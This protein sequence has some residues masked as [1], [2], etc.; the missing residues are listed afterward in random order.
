MVDETGVRYV[1]YSGD[2]SEGVTQVT[3]IM[4][5]SDPDS[6]AITGTLQVIAT[7]EP[8]NATDPS[9]TWSVENGTGS[10]S[11]DQS[12]MLTGA[13]AGLVTVKAMANDGSGIEGTIE[14]KVYLQ[15]AINNLNALNLSIYPN[16]SNGLFQIEVPGSKTN[17]L[18]YE[19]I[20]VMGRTIRKGVFSRENS[21]LNLLESPKGMYIL[22]I[23]GEKPLYTRLLVQ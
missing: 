3:S 21:Q 8:S 7:V 10:A 9:I 15:T 22:V 12:G 20:D 5:T 18:Q 13:S 1:T 23:H 6:V 4:L 19:V 14:I 17:S 2:G 11:I 16:P